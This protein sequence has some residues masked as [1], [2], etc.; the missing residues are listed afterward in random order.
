MPLGT[1][2]DPR[3]RRRVRA[4]PAPVGP[5]CRRAPGRGRVAQR[6]LPHGQPHAGPPPPALPEPPA[7]GWSARHWKLQGEVPGTGLEPVRPQGAARFK[8]AVSAFHHPGRPWAPHR[9]SEPIGRHPSNSGAV[10][11]CCL[12]LLTPEGASAPGTGHPHLPTAWRAAT[13]CVCGMT[14]FH[15]PNEG[16]P[17]VLD[18]RPTAGRSRG[19][20][21]GVGHPQ[22]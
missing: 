14:E 17:P 5:S 19:R 21:G 10:D 22:V 16:A 8:L 18:E 9:G 3:P 6:D 11:R 12:I 2:A 7:P 4:A 1:A 15:R 20:V 13:A